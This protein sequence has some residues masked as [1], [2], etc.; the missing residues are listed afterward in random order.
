MVAKQ[1]VFEDKHEYLR[2]YFDASNRFSNYH[3][4]WLRHN[5]LCC[6]HETTHERILCPSRVA[7]DMRPREI[8]ALDDKGIR[9]IWD[10]GHESDFALDW[11]L[12]HAYALDEPV[13]EIQAQN[14]AY[15]EV[16][17]ANCKDDLVVM[18]DRYLNEKGAILVRGCTLDTEQLVACLTDETFT[19]RDSHFGYIE[20]LKT[21][22]TTNKNTDQLGY[23]NA[24]VNLHTDQP[25]IEH[26]PRLQLLQCIEKA[27]EGG[28]SMLADAQQAAYYLR[29][30]DR[31][32]FEALTEIPVVFHRK[33]KNFECETR[34]PILSFESDRFYQIRSSYF[35]LAPQASSFDHMAQWYRA[36]QQFTRIIEDPAYQFRVLL[37]PQDFI[38]YD[39]Y[40]MLHGRTAFTGPRWMKGIYFDYR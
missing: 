33:Q 26:P 34:Y 7:L 18:C 39:N 3:Y 12:D 15:I 29:D 16:Q 38:L 2:V 4:F 19:L 30:L 23:T 1:T 35:T 5:C 13:V 21:D 11:L 36:Y 10:D 32:A 40:R 17:Y 8:L 6:V 24:A 28:E 25:F 31:S 14:L 9:L 27:D 20:D 22:N 37:Q